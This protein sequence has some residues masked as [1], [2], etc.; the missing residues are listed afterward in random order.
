MPIHTE[1]VKRI[2]APVLL[3]ICGNT[4]D[5]I[6]YICETKV[7]CFHFD[8]RVPAKEAR[9]IAERKISLMGN[10]NNPETLYRG[11]EQDVHR[12]VCAAL[13]AE[14]DIIG[15]ECAVPLRTPSSNLKAIV[16]S[17]RDLTC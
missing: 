9:R 13:E 16:S 14:I 7:D 1:L 12:E 17:I 2:P 5:R 8:S 15:P 11:N 4:A 6:G 3:H 10:I